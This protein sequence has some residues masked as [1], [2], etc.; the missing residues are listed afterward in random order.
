[1]GVHLY[2][3]SPTV[4]GAKY[5]PDCYIDLMTDVVDKTT[6]S[7]MMAGIR[8]TNTKPEML[9][10]RALHA[11]G[12]RFRI[13][14]KRLPGRPDVVL[15]KWKTAIQV[16]GC[17]WHRHS[18]CAKA[19]NPSSNASFWAK[20]FQANVE[21]DAVAVE[22]L[23]EKGWR[24]L[25]VWECSLDKVRME[26]AIDI[27]E[28]FIRLGPNHSVRFAEVGWPDFAIDEAKDFRSG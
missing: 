14:D 25:V 4:P 2:Q 21:R 24:I 15:P 23:M 1:M 3:V 9:V 17:F 12:F 8:A 18:G 6:R 16:H 11:R 13:H 10:R 20:K 19:T 22:G 26:E 28:D 27:I 7:R 5:D